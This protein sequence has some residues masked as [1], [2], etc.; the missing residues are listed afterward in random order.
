M[1]SAHIGLS[2]MGI[3][4]N[5]KKAI[6]IKDFEYMYCKLPV[7]AAK[8][9]S[10]EFFVGN[11][12]AGIVLQTVTAESLSK[13]IIKLL[14]SPELAAQYGDNGYRAV[15]ENY[16]WKIMEKKL[17]RIYEKVITQ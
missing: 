10:T 8:V 5:L 12:K 7:I 6:Q 9:S 11:N 17:Y 1:K 2:S 4:N 15:K 16:N 3:N 13:A 14:S